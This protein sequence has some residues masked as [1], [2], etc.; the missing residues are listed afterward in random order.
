MKNKFLIF[1]LI[2][3]LLF[4]FASCSTSKT[5]NNSSTFNI[6]TSFNPLYSFLL[7]LTDGAANINVS[8]MVP[9]TTGCLHDYQLLPKDLKVLENAD[10]FIINGAGMEGFISLAINNYPTLSILDSSHNIK[11]LK[12]YSAEDLLHPGHNKHDEHEHDHD[13]SGHDEHSHE[14]NSHIWLSLS[15]AAVQ[16]KNIADELIRLNPQNSSVYE[17]NLNSLLIGINKLKESQT[18]LLLNKN[19][20]VLS[21]NP[22]FDYFLNDSN[23]LSYYML[24]DIENSPSAYYLSKL[25]TFTNNAK[26]TDNEL[27]CIVTDINYPPSVVKAIC[28]ETNI[29]VITLNS[30][31]EGDINKDSYISAMAQNIAVLS[32]IL[33]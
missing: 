1:F 24:D 30:L 6:V 29:P 18:K 32:N 14:Y 26:N 22:I 16:V 20:K 25:I 7:Y 28:D 4:S 23:I 12:N 33:N 13:H 27:S 5:E 9:S 19:L 11:L 2:F 8:T 10:L 3:C 17:K 21:F 31:V 15:N